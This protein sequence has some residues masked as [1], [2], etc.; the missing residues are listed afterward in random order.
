MSG[1]GGARLAETHTID[2]FD[3]VRANADR[4]SRVEP[5]AAEGRVA[6][7]RAVAAPQIDA[8]N[9]A[10]DCLQVSVAATDVG[11]IEPANA[12]LVAADQREGAIDDELQGLRV[13]GPG[14]RQAEH[15]WQKR[16]VVAFS[17]QH[18]TRPTA[19]RTIPLLT[20]LR[21]KL[22]SPMSIA[23]SYCQFF[24]KSPTG[25]LKH[26]TIRVNVEVSMAV[27]L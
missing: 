10:E 22:H 23:Q 2:D 11:M 15:T 8:E 24:Q 4:H 1:K 18:S 13:V 17:S 3:L 16:T 12:A 20:Q 5:A 21:R 7:V 25:L 19:E 9:S 6:P 26:P 27:A 14:D